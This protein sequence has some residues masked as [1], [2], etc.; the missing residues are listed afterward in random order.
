M[1]SVS[2]HGEL[3]VSEKV[4]L[5]GTTMLKAINELTIS[6][7]TDILSRPLTRRPAFRG[8]GLFLFYLWKS[9]RSRGEPILSRL[10]GNAHRMPANQSSKEMTEVPDR[11]FI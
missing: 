9:C 7:T 5:F 3:L 11:V 8:G 2:V 6:K 4:N 10:H 1:I